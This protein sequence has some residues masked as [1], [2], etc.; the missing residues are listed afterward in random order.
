MITARDFR[1]GIIIEMEGDLFLVLETQHVKKENRRALVKTRLRNL[2]TGV[3]ID[4]SLRP[5]D[6]FEQAYIEMKKMQY[7]YHDQ[8]T[9]HIMDLATY[10]QVSVDAGLIGENTKF[11]K[12]NMEVTASLHKN[13]IV[14]I[15]LP[16]T[17]DLKVQYTEP[18]I[19]GDTAKGGTKPATL[20]TGAVVKVPLFINTDDT[21]KIDTRTGEYAGRV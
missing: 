1:N 15:T 2:K 6:T 17:V 10:E 11:L 13:K 21:I 12:D 5:E 7:L 14:G 19:K 4:P 20:E 18:W 3:I 9:Y 8:S 16:P